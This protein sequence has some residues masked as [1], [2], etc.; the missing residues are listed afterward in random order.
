MEKFPLGKTKPQLYV[1]S[2][3]A[4]TVKLRICFQP[5][6]VRA[7]F[8]V[9]RGSDM[10]ES[11]SSFRSTL[12]FTY[13]IE[14]GSHPGNSPYDP[15]FSDALALAAC[16]IMHR[17]ES[18]TTR[19]QEG[20]PSHVTRGKAARSLLSTLYPHMDLSS[21]ISQHTLQSKHQ[22]LPSSSLVRLVLVST[23]IVV[24]AFPR[25]T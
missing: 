13:L 1:S 8:S 23:P 14:E 3:R 15:L 6:P 4:K 22:L 2:P 17:R 21:C 10:L 9:F 5:H 25:K 19:Q 12:F 7:T 18:I 16:V 11:I 24:V 20:T